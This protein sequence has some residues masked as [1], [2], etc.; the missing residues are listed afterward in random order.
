MISPSTKSFAMWR[1]STYGG[2]SGF[3]AKQQYQSKF[4]NV[5]IC[6]TTCWLRA[7]LKIGWMIWSD[8]KVTKMW[9]RIQAFNTVVKGHRFATCPAQVLIIEPW[10][11]ILLAWYLYHILWVQTAM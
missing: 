5:L 10:V 2:S 1:E 4:P 11:F 3:E 9:K 7:L 6:S 8:L